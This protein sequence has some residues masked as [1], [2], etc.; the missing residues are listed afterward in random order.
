M[1]LHGGQGKTLELGAEVGRGGEAV[2]YRVAG[3]P[4]RLAKIY[5]TE[6]RPNYPRKLDWMA[7]HP[8]K[9]PT[10]SLNH[11]SLAWPDF[12]LYD[13]SRKLKGYCMPYIAHAVPLLE[14]FNPRR[15][16]AILPQFD[17]RYLHRTARNLAAAIG[18]LHSSG[19]V[20]GDLNES[21]VLVTPSALVTLI[22][23]DSFQVVEKRVGTE[24]LYRCPVAKLEYTPP[25]LQGKPLAEV[26]RVPDHDAFG[27]AVLIFQLL[28]DG[29][30]PFRALWLGQGEPPSLEKRIADGDFPYA[31][32]HAIPI[33]PPPNLP[34][35]D[36]L[37]PSLSE[38]F[39]RCFIDGHRSPRWRPGPALW[40]RAIDEAEA[41]LVCCSA[42]HYYAGHLASCPYCAPR[43]EKPVPSAR[44]SEVGNWSRL[45]RFRTGQS[46]AAAGQPPSSL[47]AA[48]FP[49]RV[50]LDPVTAAVRA[51]RNQ[52]ERLIR[53]FHSRPGVVR[54]W[55]NAWIHPSLAVGGGQGAAVG[56]V[57]GALV[58]IVCWLAG[59]PLAWSLILGLGG[60]AGGVLLGWR[61]GYRLAILINHLVGW[62]RFWMFSSLVAGAIS[63]GMLG[64]LVQGSALPVLLGIFL[65]AV[66]GYLLGEKAWQ[67]GVRLG[68]EKIWK[69]ISVVSA[70]ALGWGAAAIAG[71]IGLNGVGVQLASGLEPFAD[72]NLFSS[73]LLWL[74]AG[75]FSGAL[76]GAIAGL[77]VD[78]VGRVSRLTR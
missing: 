67:A 40:A 13:S 78:L 43:Q 72:D 8:P 32:F 71:R 24:I 35:L 23:T 76:A 29:S 14:V 63:G 64:K 5:I 18:A 73:A 44:P 65:G 57:P 55:Y 16:A 36:T 25:E 49:A 10:A 46:R 54:G 27:L 31:Q 2:V 15:R 38:L 17:R 61:P 28:M 3:E 74:L 45:Q 62:Q 41:A 7:A 33:A 19:Y 51:V 75:G 26:K 39:Q 52:A 4:N 58:G 37:H 56:A 70:A 21:N 66:L 59:S 47:P 6:P 11:A 48:G 12:L 53:R 1:I 22:D 9:N 34:G 30:H 60:A 68:W 50:A 42:G 20:V 69:I 77:F